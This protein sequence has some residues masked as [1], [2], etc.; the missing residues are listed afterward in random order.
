MSNSPETINATAQWIGI[1]I[2]GGIAIV[3]TAINLIYNFFQ[4]RSE[5]RYLLRENVYLQACEGVASGAQYLARFSRLD[6]D[7]NQ[8]AGV[9]ETASGWSYKVHAVANQETIDALTAT[10]EFLFKKTL[11]LIKPRVEVRQ[12]DNR[13]KSLNNESA[14]TSA[15]VQQLAT[16]IDNLPKTAPTQEVLNAIPAL[17]HQFTKARDRNTEIQKE[18]SDLQVKRHKKHLKLVSDSLKASIEYSEILTDVNVAVRKELHLNMDENRYRKAMKYSS[19]RM[20]AAWENL[21]KDQ[22]IQ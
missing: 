11:E 22:G 4:K 19:E 1:I 5:Q 18:I 16:V 17:I 2:G 12:I 14:Q 9:M 13:I 7:D 20:L 21:L 8:L 3:T 6:I 10:Q 15:F